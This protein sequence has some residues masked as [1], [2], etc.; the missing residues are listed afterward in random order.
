MLP[1]KALFAKI[2]TEIA[3]M[4]KTAVIAA[5]GSATLNFSGQA[6]GILVLGGASNSYLGLY[7]VSHN[8]G[9][10]I[11]N[12]AIAAPTSTNITVTFANGSCTVANNNT[13]GTLFATYIVAD[14]VS[15]S[16]S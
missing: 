11:Y 13:S 7:G 1:I 12:K 5:R 15:P 16:W 4:R 9:T 6:N 2:L 10:A 3:G 8:S 14:G